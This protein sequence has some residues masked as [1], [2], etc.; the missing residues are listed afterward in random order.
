GEHPSVAAEFAAVV[1]AAR[2]GD[3]GATALLENSAEHLAVA[4]RVMANI[5][6]PDLPVLTRPR[7]AP[8]GPSYLPA[9]Q[10]EPDRAFFARAEH[11]VRVRLSTFASTAPAV[12]AATMALQAELVPMYPGQRLPEGIE[13][14]ITR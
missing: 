1:R 3:T 5:V 2:R 14:E 4:V 9:R 13:Q 7:L 8:G 6:D 11:P 12:G 10:P